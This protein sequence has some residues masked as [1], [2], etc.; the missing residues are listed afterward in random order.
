MKRFCVFLLPC[1]FLLSSCNAYRI[2]KEPKYDKK[3]VQDFYGLE[4]TQINRIEEFPF[5]LIKGLKKNGVFLTTD[6][7]SYNS[8]TIISKDIP[9]ALLLYGGI[10]KEKKTGYLIYNKGGFYE[11]RVFMIFKYNDRNISCYFFKIDL[12]DFDLDD[13]RPQ[14]IEDNYHW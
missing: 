2:I 13:I 12:A 8:T 1:L 14:L 10:D 9:N 6:P 7:S 4:L 5:E 3:V 11:Y